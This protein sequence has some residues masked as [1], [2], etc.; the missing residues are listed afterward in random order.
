MLPDLLIGLHL[1]SEAEFCVTDAL[2]GGKGGGEETSSASL[3]IVK[4]TH[5][6]RERERG[7]M[8]C[9]RSLHIK[10]APL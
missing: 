6:Q 5:T 4:S 10:Q 2:T 9:R 8:P 7:G 3:H 1:A